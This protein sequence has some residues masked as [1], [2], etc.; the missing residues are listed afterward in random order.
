VLNLR[1]IE[2]NSDVFIRPI[3]PLSRG[4]LPDSAPLTVIA[5]MNAQPSQNE[6]DYILYVDRLPFRGRNNDSGSEIQYDI[7]LPILISQSSIPSPPYESLIRP[8]LWPFDTCYDGGAITSPEYLFDHYQLVGV[9]R[10]HQSTLPEGYFPLPQI[11]SR[12]LSAD[13]MHDSPIEIPIH[14]CSIWIG[15]NIPAMQPYPVEIGVAIAGVAV[16][17]NRRR[18]LLGRAA[19]LG[20]DIRMTIEFLRGIPTVS[21]WVP[22]SMLPLVPTL[23]TSSD[24]G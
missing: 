12:R 10:N 3:N 7:L 8:P 14:R 4:K 13:A 19:F 24:G 9:P 18:T 17:R 15:S 2:S 5:T 6:P 20:T 23:P 22:R 21:V 1:W 11:T 16:Q